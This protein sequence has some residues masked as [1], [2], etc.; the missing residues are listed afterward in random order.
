MRIGWSQKKTTLHKGAVLEK[1]T[2]GSDTEEV[3][4]VWTYMQNE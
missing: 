1:S 3:T 2:P 4:T